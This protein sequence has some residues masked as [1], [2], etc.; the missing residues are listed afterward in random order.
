[1]EASD[2]SYGNRAGQLGSIG[3]NWIH[4]QL[5]RFSRETEGWAITRPSII[6]C[7][8][9]R[10]YVADFSAVAS[11]TQHNLRFGQLNPRFQL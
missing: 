3:T 6:V 1:M 10:S 7:L 2:V 4:P 8:H 5:H 9:V 11:L